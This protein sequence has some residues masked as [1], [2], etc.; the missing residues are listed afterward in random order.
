MLSAF[1]LYLAFDKAISTIDRGFDFVLHFILT[2]LFSETIE[3][4]VV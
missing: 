4:T 1:S 2:A 3:I